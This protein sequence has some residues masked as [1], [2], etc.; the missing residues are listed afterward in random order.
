MFWFKIYNRVVIRFMFIIAK[1]KI[2]AIKIRAV[3]AKTKIWAI[4]I[5]AVTKYNRRVISSGFLI[6]FFWFFRI[7][8]MT[9]VPLYIILHSVLYIIL[10]TIYYI[11]FTVRA[12]LFVTFF[13]LL[14]IIC[15]NSG[16]FHY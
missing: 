15:I 4:K 16:F 13:F 10:H 1:T 12:F 7:L 5:R 11:I 9:L 2:R 6:S 3:I 8:V 14:Y